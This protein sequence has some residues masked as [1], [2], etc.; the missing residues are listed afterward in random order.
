MTGTG[1]APAVRRL[2]EELIELGWPERHA[3]LAR[4]RSEDAALAAEVE[5]L[6]A[7]AEAAPGFLERPAHESEL[8]GHAAG[9]WHIEARLSS[10]GGGDVY[11]ARRADG[12]EDWCV[13]LKVL[14]R[15]AS[16]SDARRRFEAE[17]RSL[18]S[19]NH[20][21]IVPLV[22][23]GTLADGRPYLATRLV[24]GEPLDRACAGLPLWARL[25]LFL[26]VANAVQHAHARL[27]AHCDLKP[28]NILVTR[29]GIP[30]LVDFG[31]A[32]FLSGTSS[33]E[34]ALTPGYASPE[35]VAGA[36]LGVTSD[37]WSLGVV[38]Y[39]LASG[40]RPFPGEPTGPPVPASAAVLRAGQPDAGCPAP[41][42]PAR[43]ARALSGDL[44]ALL[45]RALAFDPADRYPS[46]E[47]LARDVDS[48]LAGRPL[49]ARPATRARRSWLWVRR[50][51]AASLLGLVLFLAL[52]GG[53]LALY[54]DARR[55]R[56]EASMGWRAH[57]QA[58]LASRW[59]ENL[60]RAAGPGPE[61]ERALDEARANLARET[62]FPPE[63]E[64]RLR[65]TLGALYLEVGR[66]VD[67][68]A[69][70][71]R[72]QALTQV[73]RGFGGEDRE[74]IE[75]LLAEARRL[76]LAQAATR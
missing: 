9:P 60:A 16:G 52:L 38:L 45:A 71:E 58:V 29:E 54:R 22:D 46:V 56:A 1:L 40:K 43:L 5:G 18:A 23:A 34:A 17:R 64:G 59:I 10:G 47:A 49:A 15:A 66:P 42:A 21:Y 55:S 13:A 27:I 61:L 36:T 35:Q 31:I 44:D 50:N 70:L 76:I 30:Q 33:P 28:A 63:G 37:V 24:E 74:R 69:E 68:R 6:L 7:A 20:P 65:L 48:F 12:A 62:D 39:E 26:S 19:L 73:T 11:R 14:R 41:E 72:A 8:L 75:R 4:T 25:R 67:A 2:F 53:G 32:R 57:A 3:L 51:R